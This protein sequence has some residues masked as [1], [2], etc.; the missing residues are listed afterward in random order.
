MM[1][2]QEVA[3]TLGISLKT[4]DSWIDTRGLPARKIGKRVLTLRSELIEWIEAQPPAVRSR[5]FD[6]PEAGTAS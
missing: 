5:W 2:R 1:T 6:Q 3:N 4:V